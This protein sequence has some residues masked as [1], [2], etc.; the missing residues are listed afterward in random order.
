MP[1]SDLDRYKLPADPKPLLD[2][3]GMRAVK[4]RGNK[5]TAICPF[6]SGADQEDGF[7]AFI[8]KGIY[9]CGTKQ[10]WRGDLIKLV[11][12]LAGLDFKEA[13]AWIGYRLGYGDQEVGWKPRLRRHDF[14]APKTE[15]VSSERVSQELIDR[16]KVAYWESCDPYWALRKRPFSENILKF[17]DA[18]LVCRR[19]GNQEHGYVPL[20]RAIFPLHSCEGELL[21][22]TGRVTDDALIRTSKP[23]PGRP[24]IPKWR[25]FPGPRYGEDRKTIIEPGIEVR[26]HFFGWRQAEWTMCE[27]PR[28]ILSEGPGDVMSGAEMACAIGEPWFPLGI[29]GTTLKPNQAIRL[30]GHGVIEIWCILDADSAGEQMVQSVRR[31][32]PFATTWI[33]RL[34]LGYKDLGELSDPGLYRSM[35]ESRT[36]AY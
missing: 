8:D 36:L 12:D 26:D 10:C 21:G 29:F 6:H 25:H 3:L 28:A 1:S 13:I 14:H 22:W 16:A 9:G 5:L 35:V 30:M 24:M 2:E 20:K 32:L 18:G 15:F 17:Y 27:E 11:A 19:E 4:V 23:E 31:E 34:P 33:L 7:Y